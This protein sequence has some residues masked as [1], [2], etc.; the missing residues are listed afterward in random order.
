MRLVQV[1]PTQPSTLLHGSH[2]GSSGTCHL[3]L[4]SSPAHFHLPF[5]PVALGLHP[6]KVRKLCFCLWIQLQLP[7][8]LLKDLGQVKEPLR[9]SVPQL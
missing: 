6:Q 1:S 7:F 8:I 5:I 9:A 4:P 2:L 3:V